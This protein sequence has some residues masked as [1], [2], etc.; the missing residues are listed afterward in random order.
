MLETVRQTIQKFHLIPAGQTVVAGVSGGADSLT[1]LH[2]LHRLS[3]RMNF[4]IH[5]AT[6]NHQLRG[7]ESAA[8]AHFVQAIAHEWGIPVTADQVDVSALAHDEHLGIEVAARL[9]RYRFL[10]QVAQVV[11]ATRIVVAH[12]VD[13]QAETVLMRLL[14]GVGTRGLAGMSMLSLVPGHP[15]LLLIRPLLNI[16]RT[17]IEAYCQQ[18]KLTPRT[19]STNQDTKLLRNAIRQNVLPYLMKFNAQLSQTLN[20]LAE[21]SAI[22]NDYLDQ[23]LQQFVDTHTLSISPKQIGFSLYDF[24]DLHP[25][26]QRRLLIWSLAKLGVTEDLSHDR[27]LDAVEIGLRG[28]QGALSL[29]GNGF[30]LRVDY[31]RLVIEQ[32]V[33][34][35]ETELPLLLDDSEIVIAVPGLTPLNN[36]ILQT[37]FA[38]LVG[39][40]VGRLALTPDARLTLRPRRAGDRFAPLGMSG[41]TQKIDRWM[42][43]RK[44]PLAIRDRIPLLC[45]DD[46]IAAICLDTGWIIGEAFAANDNSPYVIYFQ[47]RDNL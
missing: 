3:D 11:G 38:P 40:K 29:L 42:I 15:D 27:I 7:E 31:D 14:R 41:H 37:S 36:W 10:A 44:I 46:K 13:D 18:H 16:T 8:D 5:V 26:L 24:R 1:L 43:N 4:H 2:M 12:H 33:A 25:A 6:L 30:H 9:A 28:R 47:F 45:V 17:Q 21:T 39:D 34:K 23:R 35:P 22:D 32:A 19:D 20:R